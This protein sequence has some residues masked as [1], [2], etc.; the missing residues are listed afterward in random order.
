M[1]KQVLSFVLAFIM[2]LGL[3]PAMTVSVSAVE[4]ITAKGLTRDDGVWLF[5]VAKGNL[6]DWAGCGNGMQKGGKGCTLCD[7]GE[8]HSCEYHNSTNGHSGIDITASKGT[9]ILA[10]ADGTVRR[11]YNNTVSG[12]T[13]FI[14]HIIN[15]D[16]GLS[17]YSVY[18]HLDTFNKDKKGTKLKEGD[19]VRTGDQIGTMGQSG[20]GA[21]GVHLHFSMFVDKSFAQGM[22]KS[23]LNVENKGWAL[24]PGVKGRILTNPS[25][26][27]Y[28][29]GKLDGFNLSNNKYKDE[30]TIFYREHCGSITYTLDKTKVSIGPGESTEFKDVTSEFIGHR[31]A[32]KS[33]ENGKYI[34]V[35]ISE[36][37]SPLYANVD[38]IK[39]WEVF[40]T[41]ENSDGWIGFKSEAN[42]KYISVNINADNNPLRAEA[43]LLKSWECFKIYKKGDD[44]YLKSR[45]NDKWV[46]M[47]KNT[48]NNPLWARVDVPASWEKFK[49]EILPTVSDGTYKIINVASKK[50]LGIITGKNGTGSYTDMPLHNQNTV[51]WKLV[52]TDPSY[53]WTLAYEYEK[54]SYII[55]SATKNVVLNASANEPKSSTRINVYNLDN[56]ST[57]STQRW[58]IESVGNDQYI[59]RLKYNKNLVLTANGEKDGATIIVK[60][61]DP[62]D[63]YQKWI[64]KNIDNAEEA[65]KTE[66]SEQ[67]IKQIIDNANDILDDAAIALSVTETV[68]SSQKVIINGKEIT[69]E[70]YNIN[71]NNYFK[72]RDLAYAL[73][74]TNKQFEVSFNEAT[75]GI[76]LMSNR[77]YTPVGG[78]MLI[79]SSKTSKTTKLTSSK[80]YLDSNEV[81]FTAYNIDGNNYF[82]LRDVMK[83]FDIYVGW[84]G[85][86]STITLDTTKSYID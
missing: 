75:N 2:C 19:K 52:E 70:A 47:E 79:N 29:D 71:G 8:K 10:P 30:N 67:I 20:T 11:V 31:I 45:A 1:R 80:V 68:P 77:M 73:N 41:V 32:I 28:K 6:S 38:W 44:Y 72:L 36:K 42:N 63:D 9:A 40:Q 27:N 76:N 62:N 23:D 69:F 83:T 7:K 55:H 53:N 4:A 60:T 56:G 3:I 26:K 82:K 22:K 65:N 46:S 61:Y 18:Y 21:A 25:I 58:I 59:I 34:T 43:D 86:T 24:K 48:E 85:N 54:D 81:K 15:D 14:E 64:F 74:G 5:P 16:S 50:Y 39:S 49:I 51:L 17:Y 66:N 33:F 84:N 35:H 57:Y 37:T 78:E 13:I 12:N